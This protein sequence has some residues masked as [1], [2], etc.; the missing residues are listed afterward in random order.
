MK[1]AAI[2]LALMAAALAAPGAQ[3]Q[4]IMGS[5]QAEACYH[6]VEAGDRGRAA[7]LRRCEAGLEDMRLTPRDRAATH[8][9]LGIL[10]HRAGRSDEALVQ[11]DRALR[12]DA[13]KPAFWHNRGVAM[14]GLEDFTGAAEHFTRA[15]DLGF[16]RPSHAYFN[17]ALSREQ[18]GDLA[19][20]YDDL[21][22]ALDANPGFALARQELTRFVV[23]PS[24]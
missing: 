11:F 6:A 24:G 17:R 7:T 21:Q 23:E 9:N 18:A 19:G 22:A 13:D 16:D 8:N 2:P 10:L 20:A 15:L 14:M 1:H 12:L 3:A 4:V 5:S